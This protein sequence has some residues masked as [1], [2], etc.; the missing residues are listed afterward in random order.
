[1]DNSKKLNEVVAAS[2]HLKK[3]TPSKFAHWKVGDVS[4]DRITLAQADEL[5]KYGCEYLAK[6][7]AGKI[8][9]TK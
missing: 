7:P 1:M 3:G 2:Y 6:N 8:T 4:I 5:F 9:I